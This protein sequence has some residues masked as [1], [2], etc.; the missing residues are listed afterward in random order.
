[1]SNKDIDPFSRHFHYIVFDEKRN[2]LIAT[3]GME[4]LLGLLS[5][6]IA[7]SAGDPYTKGRGSSFLYSLRKIGGYLVLTAVLLRVV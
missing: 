3:L 2:I 5:Q 6:L 7:G 4:T 1:V